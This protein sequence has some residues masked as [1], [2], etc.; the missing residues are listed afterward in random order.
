[1]A[2]QKQYGSHGITSRYDH[3]NS[4]DQLTSADFSLAIIKSS[5]FSDHCVTI[6]EITEDSV[7]FADPTYGIQKMDRKAF[8]N[9]WRFSAITLS[10][11]RNS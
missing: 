11:T 10:K 7:K 1:M 4:L 6:L 9:I 2:I 8:E 5:F 3:F